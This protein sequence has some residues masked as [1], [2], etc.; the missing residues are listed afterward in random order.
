MEEVLYLYL[1]PYDPLFPLICID[2]RPCQLIDDIL[3]PLPM[4][5][6]MPKR[7]DYHYKRNGVVNLFIA[8]EPKTGKRIVQITKRRTK[9]D[10]ARFLLKVAS[11]YPQAETIRVVQ[12][13]LNTHNPSSFYQTFDAIKAFQLTRKFEMHYTPKKASWLNM[14]E[15]ELSALSKQCLDRRIGDTET[16]ESEVLAWVASRNEKRVTV[17]WQFSIDAARE[18]FS[19]FYPNG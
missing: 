11:H 9:G 1:K 18:K 5:Q 19:R 4:K 17:R 12:D 8:F 2:E 3:Q 6:G 14:V 13:N 10:Y 7:E 15:I 16:L